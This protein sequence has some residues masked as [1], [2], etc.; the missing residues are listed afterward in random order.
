MKTQSD[1]ERLKA[2]WRIDPCWELEFTEGFEEHEEELREYRETQEA[3]WA[4]ERQEELERDPLD[5]AKEWMD[6]VKQSYA[7][8]MPQNAI[9][10]ALIALVERLDMLID[11]DGLD[12]KNRGYLRIDTGRP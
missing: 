1:L 4:A 6:P 5:W 11:S 2:N 12:P 9:A 8:L 10:W 7:G 3:E